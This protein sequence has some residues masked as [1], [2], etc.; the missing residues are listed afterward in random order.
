MLDL[1]DST[2]ANDANLEFIHNHFSSLRGP[3]RRS[4]AS[5]RAVRTV[6][7]VKIRIFILIFVKKYYFLRALLDMAGMEFGFE[8]RL[9]LADHFTDVQAI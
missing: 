9:H 2:A 1:G 4:V 3:G 5:C 8:K 7:A 6:C